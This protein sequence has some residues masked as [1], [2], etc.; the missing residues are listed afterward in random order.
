MAKVSRDLL[1]GLVKECLVEILSEG[2]GNDSQA[3]ALTERRVPR[4]QKKSKPVRR[5][6]NDLISYGSDNTPPVSNDRINALANS[7]AN[8]NDVMAEIF[9]DTAKNTLPKMMASETRGAAASMTERVARGDQ[10][11]RAMA[12]NDPMDVFDGASNWAALAFS[13]ALEK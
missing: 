6:V 10:A 9:R 11:T 1:K 5:N 12:A 13:D 3:A 2:L 7:A 4:K 8:G